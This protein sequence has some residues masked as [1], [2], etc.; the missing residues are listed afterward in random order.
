M[1]QVQRSNVLLTVPDE[2]IEKYVAKGFNV[3]DDYGRIIKQSVP[4]SLSELQKAFSEHVNTIKQLN[5][6]IAQHEKT[7]NDLN[8]RIALLQEKPAAEV[9]TASAGPTGSRRK[10]NI[11]E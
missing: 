4:T 5:A 10:R 6:K 9:E 1:A 11:E 7:I 3:I 8:A 2:D